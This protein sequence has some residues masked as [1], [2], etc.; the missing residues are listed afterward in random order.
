MVTKDKETGSGIVWGKTQQF[1]HQAFIS[2]EKN[3]AS[4][5]GKRRSYKVSL[6]CSAANKLN[7]PIVSPL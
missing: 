6:Y 4:S 3:W 5:Y 7:M 1:R 2:Y